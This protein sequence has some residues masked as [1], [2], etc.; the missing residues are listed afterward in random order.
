M[1][2]AMNHSM[3]PLRV[4]F[5]VSALLKANANKKKF[6][7][8]DI[9]AETVD[10]IDELN[11]A[12]LEDRENHGKKTL[13][14][15]KGVKK[16]KEVKVSD[17]DPESGYLYRENKTEVLYLDH[18]TTV[19]KYNIITDVHVPPGNTHNSKPYLNRLD[20][21]VNDSTF[22]WKQEKACRKTRGF[23]TSCKHFN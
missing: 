17:T 1:L 20:L 21:Q 11:E 13:K 4:L 19:L 7:K 22:L 14:E 18:C 3:V 23:S 12:A 5:T 10:Y 2:Q 8:Q 9:H 16:T 6:S 15:K